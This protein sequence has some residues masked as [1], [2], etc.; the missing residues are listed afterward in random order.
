MSKITEIQNALSDLNYVP[1]I[2]SQMSESFALDKIEWD[3]LDVYKM[4]NYHTQA[5]SVIN[6]SV[7]LI[8][9]VINN[10]NSIIESKDSF[11][12]EATSETA[13]NQK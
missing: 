4:T 8:T 2:L 3:Q 7:K 10:I 5:D 13:K 1:I 9:E 12:S 11:E 6:L